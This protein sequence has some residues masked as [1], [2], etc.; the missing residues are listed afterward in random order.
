MARVTPTT[1]PP[2]AP[3][4]LDD[5]RSLLFGPRVGRGS[6]ATVFRAVIEGACGV[7]RTVAVKLFDVVA[8]DERDLVVP[9]IGR[10]IRDA[11]A[12]HHPNIVQAYEFGSHRG[13]QPFA[14]MEL[15]DGRSLA[16]LLEAFD[17]QEQKVPPDLALFIGIEVA[18]ALAGARSS[19]ECPL[20]PHGDLSARDVLLSSHGEVK[21]SDF[22]ISAAVGAASAVR[23][24]GSISRRVV[25]LAPEVAQG[26]RADARADVFSLGAL[27]H[28]MLVGPRFSR[29]NTDDEVLMR[30]VEGSFEPRLF[31]PRLPPE[32]LD[33]IE[34]ATHP[35]PERRLGDPAILAYELRRAAMALGV[36]DGR[37]F[38]RH[39]L[40]AAFAR[41][42]VVDADG[43]TAPT[44]RPTARPP[45]ASRR[46]RAG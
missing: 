5:R 7:R 1:P 30:A 19:R 6:R 43:P 11:A 26:G 25:T 24:R 21:V 42:P 32:I 35:E 13:K 20:V 31:G 4:E 2:S 16:E 33:L 22:G 46:S 10:A 8:S 18:E 27:L 15:V 37:V 40:E 38:L 28:V 17:A 14:E 41:E 44:L 23:S 45:A 12:I 29:D 36:G 39:A 3:V 9:R 34:R